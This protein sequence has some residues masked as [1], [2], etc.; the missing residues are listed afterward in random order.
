MNH[1]IWCI[2]IGHY[3]VNYLL[4]FGSQ[5][6]KQST[7]V[8][9]YENPRW[10]LIEAVK[11]CLNCFI[12][13]VHRRTNHATK[14]NIN[15]AN[16]LAK[17]LSIDAHFKDIMHQNGYNALMVQSEMNRGWNHLC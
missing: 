9:L 6:L 1:N 4:A 11:K 8:A 17:T 2:H 13:E 14:M 15:G 12:W 10:S 3:L 5:S 16:D 7:V